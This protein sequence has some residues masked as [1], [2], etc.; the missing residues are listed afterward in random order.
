MQSRRPRAMPTALPCAARFPCIESQPTPPVPSRRTLLPPPTSPLRSLIAHS[1]RL[2]SNRRQAQYNALVTAIPQSGRT[3]GTT[4]VDG[5]AC[6]DAARGALS[7]SEQ[8]AGR[9]SG[10]VRQVDGTAYE[11][12]G[13]DIAPACTDNVEQ[14]DSHGGPKGVP[15]GSHVCQNA[16]SGRGQAHNI[17]P[18]A[19]AAPAPDER[20]KSR[21]VGS[22]SVSACLR[23]H[24]RICHLLEQLA[25]AI[26]KTVAAS[27]P[28]AGGQMKPQ[29]LPTACQVSLLSSTY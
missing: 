6:S 29:P 16:V 21:S 10:K 28:G 15:R 13:T 25:A 23:P 22:C 14:Q 8:I 18:R 11:M 1:G 17:L 5:A 12:Q 19:S 7:L 24:S 27:K 3:L 2:R 4:A 9:V 20:G 26:E